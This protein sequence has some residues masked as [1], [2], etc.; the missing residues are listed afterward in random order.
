MHNH[1][2]GDPTPSED[3]VV[4]TRRLEEAGNTLGIQVLDHIVVAVGGVVSIREFRGSKE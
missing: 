4:V 2:S 3:D 1:P